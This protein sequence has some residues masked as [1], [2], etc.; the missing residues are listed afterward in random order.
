MAVLQE[1]AEEEALEE[2]G[3]GGRDTFA[4]LAANTAADSPE[5]VLSGEE[6]DGEA[7]TVGTGVEQ[8]LENIT[9][10]MKAL[11]TNRGDSSVKK[12]SKKDRAALK[13]TFRTLQAALESGSC[14]ETHVRLK[15]GDVM[16]VATWNRTAQLNF[17]RRY[18]ST[19]FQ[20]H[21]QYNPLLHA[22]FEISPRQDRDEEEDAR[23]KRGK[24]SVA[25]KALTLGRKGD[26]AMAMSRK[27]SRAMLAEEYA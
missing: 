7:S 23:G 25:S 2:A 4:D 8:S 10:R 19:G 17:L 16:T 12:R 18:L 14:P 20:A 26:R 3:A 22:V 27:G 24:Q 6:G 11:A 21:L 9:D 5:G 1:V 13:S 15:K